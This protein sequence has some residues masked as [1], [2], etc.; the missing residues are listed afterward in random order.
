M[1]SIEFRKLHIDLP[2]ENPVDSRPWQVAGILFAL[3]ILMLIAYMYFNQ[4]EAPAQT[5]K[6]IE[7][8]ANPF[9]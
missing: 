7:V 3:I 8:V 9:S 1:P 2:T 6:Q 5:S 4:H